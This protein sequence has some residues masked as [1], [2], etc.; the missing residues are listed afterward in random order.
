[1][2]KTV[3]LSA[4]VLAVSLL[5]NA[6]GK[7]DD[8][9][10]SKTF[11][12]S[13]LKDKTVLV[14]D[15]SC[16]FP[17]VKDNTSL[18]IMVCGR[19]NCKSEDVYVW[20]R[21]EGMTGVKI[22]WTDVTKSERKE[23]VNAALTNS[24]QIDLIMRCKIDTD[25]LTQYGKSGL[26]LDLAKDDMLKKY[27]PNCWAFLQSHPDALASIT[28]PDGTIYA[29]PQVNSGAEL[30][31]SRKLFINKKWLE[32]V[33]M[34]VPTTTEELYAL[35]KAFKEQDANGNGN[36]NDEIPLCSADWASIQDC[37]FGAFGLANRGVHNT[38]VDCDE[39][40][41][42]V[43]LIVSS[44]SYKSYLEYLSKLYTEGL[45]DNYMFTM[46]SEQWNNNISKDLVGVF[47][48]TNLA[49]VPADKTDNWIAV[50]EALTGPNG[51]KLWTAIRANFHSTGAA[52]IPAACKN[53]ELVLKWLDYFWTDE[54]TLFYHM[55]VEDETFVANEDGSYDYSQKIYDEMK[56]KNISFDDAV[57]K[58]S[59]YPGGGNPTV[60]IAP[61]FM[62]GE[63][64]DVPAAAARKLFEYGPTEYWPSFTFTTDENERLVAVKSD[65]EKYCESARIDFITG[66]KKF[67]EWDDY[68]TQLEKLGTNDMLKVYQAAVDRY[69]QLSH[70]Q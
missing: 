11:V 22:N 1:M 63:M 55:G 59:P 14:G 5:L 54:G 50:D 10:R 69:Y 64:A 47:A 70:K 36:S 18:N 56:S 58:Y 21:Y 29:L 33:N 27:A 39:T 13:S 44:D 61:Y 20:K 30:R 2:R 68:K 46:T 38:S 12:T 51:D 60:E 45:M 15:I 32:N 65:I 62:G 49:G 24:S 67:N 19:D 4:I 28:N 17:L 23:K 26:I 43:R 53:P 52:V 31:V 3:K 37:L 9:S 35:L 7:T 25:R 40:T 6:C 57:S 66:T 42:K 8:S 34:S 16:D 48:S 41:G